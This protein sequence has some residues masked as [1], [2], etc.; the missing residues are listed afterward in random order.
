AGLSEV[1]PQYQPRS[2]LPFF[3]LATVLIPRNRVSIFQ[4]DPTETLQER[5]MR[6]E[7][8]LFAIHPETWSSTGLDYMN[9]LHE[10]PCGEI[11]QVAPTAS[12]RTVFTVRCPK[13][14][15]AHFLKLHY[16]RR[17]S[18]FNRRL[19]RKNIHNSI[20]GSR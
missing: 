2:N 8:V 7:S 20:E 17:I 13:D 10:M 5:Y 12:T 15:P 18:R 19:R 14:V 6:S 3:E 1:A 11:I 4:A 9:E 16:P